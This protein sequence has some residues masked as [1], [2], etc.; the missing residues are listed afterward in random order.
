V[1]DRQV[2]RALALATSF[3][4]TAAL[5]ATG[6]VL[7]GRWLDGRAHSTPLFTILGLLAGL[8][9]GFGVF[10]RAVVRLLGEGPR[11]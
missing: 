3:G 10:V 1:N 8:G 2:L 4:F 9:A 5:L 7:G 11:R 6:G